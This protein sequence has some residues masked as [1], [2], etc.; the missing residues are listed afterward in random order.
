MKKK[1]KLDWEYSRF[2]SVK[3][4]EASVLESNDPLSEREPRY[5]LGSERGVHQWRDAWCEQR[6]RRLLE[7]K[8][9]CRKRGETWA[10]PAAFL[11]SDTWLLLRRHHLQRACYQHNKHFSP[12]LTINRF[13][14]HDS[15]SRTSIFKRH[16]TLTL[17][18]SLLSEYWI[19][20]WKNEIG[21]RLKKKFISLKIKLFST[22]DKSVFYIMR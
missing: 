9:I 10:T 19:W 8:L 22:A 17:S 6:E 15:E 21:Y 2:F 1:R 20:I 7:K 16:Q 13:Y 18:C 4:G 14:S 11:R 12:S 3:C 5:A